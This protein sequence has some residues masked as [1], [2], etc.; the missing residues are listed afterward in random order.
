MPQAPMTKLL[1]MKLLKSKKDASSSA[2][3]VARTT[4]AWAS[5]TAAS[6][7][8]CSTRRRVP[9]TRWRLRKIHDAE[10]K[11]NSQTLTQE[12]GAVRC[13]AHVVHP[14]AAP[15]RP[16]AGSW[17]R[18]A[19]STPMAA[20]RASCS[21]P[22][23]RAF[24]R[25]ERSGASASPARAWRSLRDGL[26]RARRRDESSAREPRRRPVRNRR[27][28]R[29]RHAPESPGPTHSAIQARRL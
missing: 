10:L 22:G 17:T 27:R 29:R 26:R 28:R 4:T 9:S 14:A 7:R 1:K 24:R 8:R 3:A 13:E 19:S 25:A 12:V 6:P 5:S 11:I 18:T 23:A 21:R 15:P 20:R 2:R 16:K